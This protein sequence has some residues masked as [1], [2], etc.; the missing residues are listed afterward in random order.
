MLSGRY[1]HLIQALGLG[2]VWLKKGFHIKN[3]PEE[4]TP[5]ATTATMPINDIK[6]IKIEPKVENKTEDLHEEIF[7]LSAYTTTSHNQD[8]ILWITSRPFMNLAAHDMDK[9]DYGNLLKQLIYAASRQNT[10]WHEF[11]DA[12]PASGSL[13]IIQD[14]AINRIIIL[15][16]ELANTIL[17]N[18]N[19]NCPNIV[20]PSPAQML[21]TPSTKADAWEKLCKF[22]NY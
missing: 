5:V 21:R 18:D 15:G 3:T 11:L 22:M 9:S 20:L 14:K 13:K 17:K 19:I 10:Q 2:P 8:N 4:E 1:I 12:N 6:E 7:L 16:K